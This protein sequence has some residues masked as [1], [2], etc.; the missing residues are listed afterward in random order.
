MIET[1]VEGSPGSVRTAATWVGETLLGQVEEAGRL[2]TQARRRA[3]SDWEGEASASYRHVAGKLVQASDE[4][5]HDLGKVAEKLR[6]YA[7]K[8]THIQDRMRERRG[9]ATAGGLTVAGTVVQQPPEPV[10]PAD[11]PAGST[12]AE[13]DDWDRRNAAF[14]RANDKVELYNRLATEVTDDRERLDEWIE[15]NLT[16]IATATDPTLLS[17]LVKQ[18]Q[19][20]P[21]TALLFSVDLRRGRLDEVSRHYRSTADRLRAERAE[22]RAARRSGNPA[23]RAAGAA[24][25]TRGN[26]AAARGLDAAAEGAERLAR[27]L[28]LVGTALTVGLAADDI[29]NGESPGRVVTSEALAVGAGVAA[30]AVAVTL[31]APVLAVAAVG[32]VA[33]VGVGMLAEY[34]WD[35]WVP[36]DV[37]EAVDEGLRDFGEGVADAAG[38]MADAAGDAL[39]AVT[40]W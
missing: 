2:G 1:E 35:H 33:A 4:Q 19:K 9:E 21:A 5:G 29:A 12:R 26:R 16:E 10:R 32:T 31:G 38:D 30:G 15:A 17:Y 39:D 34:A 22:A 3:D 14:E 11:L 37:T 7:V 24:T 23:R 20:L 8:L 18:F 36:E 28:P 25:D 27:R 40:P 13:S 6:T